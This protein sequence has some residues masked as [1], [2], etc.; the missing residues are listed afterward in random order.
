MSTC[1]LF[2]RI[3]MTSFGSTMKPLCCMV[4]G[5][6][7]GLCMVCYYDECGTLIVEHM[8]AFSLHPSLKEYFSSEVEMPFG[9][10]WFTWHIL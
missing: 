2:R 6:Y 3:P 1:T 10:Y 7:V 9:S 8:K 4:Y 5:S